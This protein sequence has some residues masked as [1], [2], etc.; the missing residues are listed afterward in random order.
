MVAE[1]VETREIRVDAS[2]GIAEPQLHPWGGGDR[3][4]RLPGPAVQPRGVDETTGYVTKTML[5]MPIVT[6]DGRR[7]G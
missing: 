7:L 1:G 2:S 6:R 3:G 5:T 4:G